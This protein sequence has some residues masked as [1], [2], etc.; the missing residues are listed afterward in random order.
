M[1]EA[2]IS[3]KDDKKKRTVGTRWADFQ[4]VNFAQNSQ[5]LYIMMT[6]DEK[7]I[8]QPRGYEDSVDGYQKYLECG[9]DY[10]NK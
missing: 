3:L 8:T 6:P 1:P 4:V 7:V 5:P 9:L 10:F 2:F